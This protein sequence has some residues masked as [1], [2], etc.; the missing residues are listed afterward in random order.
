MDHGRIDRLLNL[1]R[2]LS[3]NVDYTIPELSERLD[4]SKRSIFRYL[5]S[6][7]KAHFAV[8]KKSPNTHKLLRMPVRRIDLSELVHISEEEAHILHALLAALSGDSQV[9]INLEQKI[10]ALFDATS[11]TEII[12]NRRAAE[13]IMRL[14]EAMDEKMQVK[15]RNYES[16][17]TESVSDRII[18]PIRFS[19][20]Y[21]D[22]YAY[23]TSSGQI[24]T[25]KIARI[26]SVEILMRDWQYEDKH[27]VIEPDCFRMNGK[28]SSNVTL[29][30]TLKAKNLLIE[31][32]PLSL[33]DVIQEGGYWYLKTEV[34]DLAGVGR[35]YLGL[36]DQISIVDSPELTEYVKR[37][38]RKNLSE[39]L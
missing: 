27:E 39:Y 13:H 21:T 23:E 4:I 14:K 2:L 8:I 12:G 19:S 17:N 33:K 28:Q 37:H 5:D 26:G 7:R 30:M 25:F 16:G 34:K 38:I 18:E 24:K 36:S 11:V 20:N 3:S 22:V 10:S 6:F 1:M 35:F 9:L 29:R 32:Y 31:E 15:L